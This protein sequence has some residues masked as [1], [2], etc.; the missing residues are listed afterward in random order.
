MKYEVTVDKVKAEEL[1][2]LTDEFAKNFGVD[3]DCH[4]HSTRWTICN[5]IWCFKSNVFSRNFN[6]EHKSLVQ[7]FSV[8]W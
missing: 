3:N 1:P 6:G 5:K 7:S 4:L 8:E 2:E